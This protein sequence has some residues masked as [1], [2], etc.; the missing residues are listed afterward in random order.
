LL[1]D[2][3]RVL[4]DFTPRSHLGGKRNGVIRLGVEPVFHPMRL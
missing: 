4:V 3:W 1:G 2:G